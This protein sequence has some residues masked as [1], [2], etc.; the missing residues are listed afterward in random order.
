MEAVRRR[1]RHCPVTYLRDCW[2][3]GEADATNA[4][5]PN[6]WSFRQAVQFG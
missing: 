3:D 2:L 1:C 4:F 5:C 6:A